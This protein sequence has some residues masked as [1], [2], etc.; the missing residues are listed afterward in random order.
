[1]KP[2]WD[3]ELNYGL[4]GLGQLNVWQAEHIDFTAKPMDYV[5]P[6]V[7]L[8]YGA[9]M[10]Q[11][12]MGCHMADLKGGPN[13]ID[14]FPD[15]PDLTQGGNL[16]KWTKDDFITILRTGIRPDGSQIDSRH[17]PWNAFKYLDQTELDALY[18]YLKSLN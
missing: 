7:S 14:D 1:V 6:N 5:A 9:I 18:L 3:T 16:G 15:A 8:E 4:A 17:M 10:A 12:C 11:K 2:I 13:K